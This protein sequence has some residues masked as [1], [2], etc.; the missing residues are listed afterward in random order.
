MLYITTKDQKDAHT[1]YKTLLSDCATDGGLYIPMRIP[2]YT[3]EEIA[4]L[5]ERSFG[6]VVA[7]ILNYFFSAQLTAWDV[8]FAIG[9][10]SVKVVSLGRKIVVSE[11]WHNPESAYSG[12]ERSL[13]KKLSVNSGISAIPT[14][15]AKIAIRIAVLFGVYGE[16]C[17]CGV[18]VFGE[19]VDLAMDIGEYFAPVAAVYAKKMGLPVG[20]LLCCCNSE[21]GAAWDLIHRNELSTATLPAQL[22]LGLERLLYVMYGESE[23]VRFKDACEKR[24]IYSVD[25]EIQERLSDMMFCVVVG[26]E[27]LD[28]VINS[29]YRTDNY[30]IDH[31]T[32]L[33]FGAIRDYRS[34]AGESKTTLLFA[35]NDPASSVQTILKA[36]GMSTDEFYK[37]IK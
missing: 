20:K 23:L 31:N 7:Q 4:D 10:N 5:K 2:C 15:W 19:T 9:R 1:A 27:R 34:K 36:T 25:E 28:S 8:D 33:T 35:E 6:D 11:L 30:L 21:A 32:A 22:R 3:T 24:G 12:L 14:D 37:L 16:L 13:F 17:R 26:K 18:A 29:V